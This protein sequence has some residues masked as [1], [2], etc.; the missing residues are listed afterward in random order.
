MVEAGAQLVL[1]RSLPRGHLEAVYAPAKGLSFESMLGSACRERDLIM[2]LLA[3]RICAPSS[4]LA[5]LSWFAD[6][7]L[8]PGLGPVSTDDLY[9]AMDWLHKRQG[10]I[11]KTLARKYLR[12][13]Q[14]PEKLALFDLSSSWV[15][16]THN[17]LAAHGYSR[18]K[19][20][21]VEQIEYGML[22][23]RTGIPIAVRAILIQ[24][25]IQNHSKQPDTPDAKTGRSPETRGSSCL[26]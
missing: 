4:K 11:E 20:P 14:N 3:A 10:R 23:T 1:A 12:T 18:D 24:N 15:T 5:T 19:K 17:P 9:R 25:H 6:T 13:G 22:A 26:N 16:G 2:A 8:G 7:T 21:G